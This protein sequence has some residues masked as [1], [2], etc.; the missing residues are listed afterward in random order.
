MSPKDE[1]STG[2]SFGSSAMMRS[3]DLR[4][5]FFLD[6]RSAADVVRSTEAETT[7]DAFYLILGN[8]VPVL[9]FN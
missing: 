9:D 7:C 2:P 3:F 5:I 4:L 6:A 1:L 8:S